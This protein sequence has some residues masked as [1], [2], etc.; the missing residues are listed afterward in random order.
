MGQEHDFDFIKA[1]AETKK[2]DGKTRRMNTRR[3]MALLLS[4]VLAAGTCLSAMAAEQPD[5]QTEE[6][7]G[8]ASTDLEQAPEVE[9]VEDSEEAVT[10]GTS[11]ENVSEGIGSSEETADQTAA[12]AD[13]NPE[14]S[15][16]KEETGSPETA[17]STESAADAL[18]SDT[19]EI[20]PKEEPE[21]ADEPKGGVEPEGAGESEGAEESEGADLS[22]SSESGDPEADAAWLNDYNYCMIELDDG[23]QAVLLQQYLGADSEIDVPGSVQIDGITY[24]VTANNSWVWQN[25]FTGFTVGEGFIFTENSQYF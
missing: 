22:E 15:T 18:T 3:L 25:N 23:T 24:S 5:I 14:N 20:A 19:A 2:C 10:A 11:E 9:Q 21:A 8:A 7:A 4:V 17:G 13:D 12:P 16:D 1:K 6:S